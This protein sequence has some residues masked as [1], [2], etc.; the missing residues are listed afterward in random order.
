MSPQERRHGHEFLGLLLPFG[1][2]VQYRPPTPVLK[3]QHKFAPKT[4]AGVFLGWH[5]LLGG[6]WS[7]DYWVGDLED[8]EE[9]KQHVRVFQV[10]EVVR[11]E[12]IEFPLREI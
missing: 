7:G 1:A 5:M 11:P 6:V 10:K 9:G 8:F 12:S 3:S 2:R 4:R